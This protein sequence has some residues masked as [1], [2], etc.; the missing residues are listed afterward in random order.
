MK[1]KDLTGEIFGK[2]SVLH[3]DG[4]YYYPSGKSCPIWACKCECGNTIHIKGDTLKH[5]NLLSC[6]CDE[7]CSVGK[8]FGK[9]TII[10]LPEF[11]DCSNSRKRI[12]YKC[13]C[14]CGNECVVL[15]DC[16]LNN[17]TKSCGCLNR[18]MAAQRCANRRN[19]NKFVLKDGYYEVY[20]E[21]NRMFLIDE[22]KR[23]TIENMY[24]SFND[25]GYVHSKYNKQHYLLHR[26]I[27]QC[28]DNMVID[29]IHGKETRF[30]NRMSNLRICTNQENTCNQKLSSNNTSGCTGVRKISEAKWTAQ[31]GYKNRKIHLGTYG[32]FED[33]VK[34]RKE[35][36]RKYFNEWSYDYSQNI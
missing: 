25:A 31:I 16:L 24:W 34:A 32:S 19:R 14:D 27:T 21:N 9:L 13:K 6:G 22:D 5:T 3:R 10:S 4:T 7:S 12:V 30:D 15:R 20:D 36:E 26:F 1:I 33:A 29:H 2:L 35:A 28:P 23:S 17:K 18:E 11:K 8:R